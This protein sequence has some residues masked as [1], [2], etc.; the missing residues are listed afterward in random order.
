MY[1]FSFSKLGIQYICFEWY[2]ISNLSGS[3]DSSSNSSTKVGPNRDNFVSSVMILPVCKKP[4]SCQGVLEL[5][6]CTCYG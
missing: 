5:E 3:V 1:Y 6:I 4:E 2:G